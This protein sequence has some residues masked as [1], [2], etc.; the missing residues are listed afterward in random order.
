VASS[1][2]RAMGGSLAVA[3]AER[4]GARIVCRLQVADVSG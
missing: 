3:D 4:G 1:M 2:A